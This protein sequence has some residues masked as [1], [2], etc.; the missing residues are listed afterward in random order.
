MK[1]KKLL[2]ELNNKSDILIVVQLIYRNTPYP[3]FVSSNLGSLIVIYLY[4]KFLK[5]IKIIQDMSLVII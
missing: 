2:G 5:Y 1:K 4:L 3:F